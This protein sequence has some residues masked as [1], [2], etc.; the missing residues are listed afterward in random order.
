[1]SILPEMPSQTP[2]ETPEINPVADR[3][4]W[5]LALELRH[6]ALP[7]ADANEDERAPV[8]RRGVAA[9]EGARGAVADDPR[10][11]A[12]RRRGG[13]GDLAKPRRRARNCR[14]RAEASKRKHTHS[15]PFSSKRLPSKRKPPPLS[16][17]TRM[18]LSATRLPKTQA[19]QRRGDAGV[20]QRADRDSS[21]SVSGAAQCTTGPVS[22]IDIQA[23]F[24]DL[25]PVQPESCSAQPTFGEF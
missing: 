6:P 25:G 13:G 20:A 15:V 18:R 8:V 7:D 14:N 16:Q 12:R 17:K 19:F 23:I 9:K 1:M 5:R 11:V 2:S 24:R 4:L 10:G 22:S 21:E 3:G